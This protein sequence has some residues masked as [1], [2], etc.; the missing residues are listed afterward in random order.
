MRYILFNLVVFCALAYL[1]TGSGT[2]PRDWLAGLL[3]GQAAEVPAMPVP[4]SERRPVADAGRERPAAATAD[5][6]PVPP[7]AAVAP[8]PAPTPPAVAAAP[9]PVETAASLPSRL[10]PELREA[11]VPPG[12]ESP[13]QA[14]IGTDVPTPP[15]AP[16]FMTRADRRRELDRLIQDMEGRFIDRLG[17]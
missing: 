16:A 11:A 12:Q 6:A 1:A 14:V 17:N 9:A 15:E 4:V 10:V 8:A 5:P 13:S 3:P 2:D 7:A